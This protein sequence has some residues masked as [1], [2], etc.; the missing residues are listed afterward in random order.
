M[1]VL[2]ESEAKA[3]AAECLAS[4]HI[5]NPHETTTRADELYEF[6]KWNR[7][8][9]KKQP[10]YWSEWKVFRLI[11]PEAGDEGIHKMSVDM[12]QY[13]VERSETDRDYWDALSSTLYKMRKYPGTSPLCCR[14][15]VS[16]Q[17]ILQRGQRC[18]LQQTVAPCWRPFKVSSA[19]PLG[20]KSNAFSS[21][22]CWPTDDAP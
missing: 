4:D 18:P 20:A 19:H 1:T 3:L 14:M 8:H 21:E 11:D 17:T 6:W 13:Y 15:A 12:A 5:D 2:S 22:L 16:T 7:L 9:A 10:A